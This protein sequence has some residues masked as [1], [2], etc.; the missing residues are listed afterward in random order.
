MTYLYEGPFV[1]MLIRGFGLITPLIIFCICLIFLFWR[2]GK[3]SLI[4][5]V[6]LIVLELLDLELLEDIWAYDF[7]LTLEE[8]IFLKNLEILFTSL[9][10]L[11]GMEGERTEI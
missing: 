10:D 3:F 5:R 9:D 6:F 7:L 11:A 8:G 1:V 2:L 4:F